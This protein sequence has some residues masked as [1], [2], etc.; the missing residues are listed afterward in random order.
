MRSFTQSLPSVEEENRPRREV[1]LP[2][3]WRDGN[4]RVHRGTLRPGYRL[5]VCSPADPASFS[6]GNYHGTPIAVLTQLRFHAGEYPVG[7]S[8]L[9]QNET[10]IEVPESW[11]KKPRGSGQSP[12]TVGSVL[13]T[14]VERI[15]RPY[16]IKKGL[17]QIR[18]PSDLAELSTIPHKPGGCVHGRATKEAVSK[19]AFGT[20]LRRFVSRDG[21][22]GQPG[23]NLRAGKGLRRLPH[24]TKV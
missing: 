6:P 4:L 20:A 14:H 24:Q 18:D 16:R 7:R 13:L 21:N 12:A 23:H 1:T 17:V 11:L 9:A 15:S 10:A 3:D 22:I 2:G 8:S 19:T 5:A